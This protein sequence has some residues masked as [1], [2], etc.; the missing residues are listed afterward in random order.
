MSTSAKLLINQLRAVTG[1]AEITPERLATVL[2]SIYNECN[3]PA[4]ITDLP[5]Y[6]E[7]EH[8]N[9]IGTTAQT[10]L[11]KAND[12][13]SKAQQALN[14][15][16]AQGGCTC[17]ELTYAEYSSLCS[18]LEIPAIKESLFPNA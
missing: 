6:L 4:G 7:Q 3:E 14:N 18:S 2:D 15:I 9:S 12:A 13:A 8:I 1:D 16:A 5:E 11:N 10:A 17:E